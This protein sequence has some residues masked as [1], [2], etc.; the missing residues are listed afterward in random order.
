MTAYFHDAKPPNHRFGH[1]AGDELLG[2][3]AS[4]LRSNLRDSDIVAR[5]GGDEFGILL[6]ETEPDAI[7]G[8][9]ARVRRA[10]ARWRGTHPELRLSLSIGW[11]IPEDGSDLRAALRTADQRM[12]LAKREA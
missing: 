7:D 1:V 12:Y 10:C 3:A 8:L 2:A 9:M 6:P 4:V 5:I 11:A